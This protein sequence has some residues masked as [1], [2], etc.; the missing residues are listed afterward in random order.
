MPTIRTTFPVGEAAGIAAQ[1]NR[2]E[3]MLAE[4][5]GE[6]AERSA[7]SEKRT[8]ELGEVSERLGQLSKQPGTRVPKPG[9]PKIA[10]PKTDPGQL[11]EPIPA[12][13]TG[14]GGPLTAG[15]NIIIV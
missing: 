8:Q 15:I 10:L 2:E 13:E 3:A 4:M 1:Q 9:E 5:R 14:V 11:E 12:D 7:A 6:S